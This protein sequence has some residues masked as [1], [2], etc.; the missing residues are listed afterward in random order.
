[1]KVMI[2]VT[3]LL[4][5]GH[6]RRALT[7]ARAF[8]QAGHDV[9]LCSGGMPVDGLD[10]GTVRLLQL[11]ELRSDGVNFTRLLDSTGHPADTA[12]LTARRDRLC[13]GLQ[14]FAPDILIT[15]L[16]PFG[17][18]VLTDEFQAL[19]KTAHA[20]PRAPVILSSVRDIL[21]PPSKP[22]KAAHTDD[23]I[24]DWYDAVLVHSDPKGTRL[25]ASWPVSTTL[26]PRLIYTGYV[27]PDAI[28]AQP[29]RDGL[30]EILVSAGGGPVGDPLFRCAASA[31][32]LKPH[33]PWRLLI[34]GPDADL[35]IAD[36]SDGGPAMIEPAR[37]DF[38]QM[39]QHAA[40]SVSLCGYNTALEVLR[41]G[42]PAV[43]VP[44]DDGGE[45][46]QTLRAQSLAHMP[47][48]VTLR[49]AELTPQRLCDALTQAMAEPRRQG[50]TLQFDGAAETVRIATRMARDRQ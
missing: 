36:L 26:E 33:R 19:L 47:G 24:R 46:E 29:G 34:G 38:Q 18:R 14:V 31:A 44:F 8:A 21:A 25:N 23:L 17:R 40:A 48:I 30:D 49:K 4:G 45:V 9:L 43:F 42:L 6:L 7:L 1:M 10:T 15:E 27:C 20:L 3:H 5:T 39:L 16:F 2:V 22:A 41:A 37:R 50:T 35:R 28:A 32:R 12:T 11:P 13:N